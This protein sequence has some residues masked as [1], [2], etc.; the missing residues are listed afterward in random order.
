MD[1]QPLLPA[2]PV[3]AHEQCGHGSRD[4]IYTWAQQ[5]GLPLTNTDL[6]TAA[7]ECQPDMPTAETNTE[8]LQI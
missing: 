5:H 6:A 2:L 8:Q 3:I 4:G 7:A 1:S